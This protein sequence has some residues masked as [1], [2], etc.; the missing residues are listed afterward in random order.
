MV[1]VWFYM[2]FMW[3]YKVFYGFK[4]KLFLYAYMILYVLCGFICHYMGGYIAFICILHC[5][6]VDSM[7]V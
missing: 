2:A 3:F 5:F 1:A 4:F 7:V 6:V